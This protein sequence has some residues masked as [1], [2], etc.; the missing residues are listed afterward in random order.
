MRANA[1]VLRRMPD[2]EIHPFSDEH[3][4][5]AARLLAARHRRHRLSEPLLPERFEDPEGA[6]EELRALRE[7][8]AS[9]VACLR[10]DR[11]AGY[12]LDFPRDPEVWGEN[13]WVD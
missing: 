8:G 3:L 10:K 1:I 9:G 4:D 2:A 11:L 5:G 6:G 7:R 12:L 13:V